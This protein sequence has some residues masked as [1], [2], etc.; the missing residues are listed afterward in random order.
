MCVIVGVYAFLHNNNFSSFFNLA[1]VLLL[2]QQT[3]IDGKFCPNS[4]KLYIIVIY[5]TMQ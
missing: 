3:T 2:V 1:E 4:I 5:S